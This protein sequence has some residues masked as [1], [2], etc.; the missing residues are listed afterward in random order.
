MKFYNLMFILIIVSLS[1]ITFVSAVEET[2]KP[3]ILERSHNQ[4]VL[5]TCDIDGQPCSLS[6]ACNVS[7]FYPNS[8]VIINNQIA[9]RDGDSYKYSL[10]EQ[11][12]NELGTHHGIATCRISEF[13]GIINFDYL[14][15]PS[16]ADPISEGQGSVIVWVIISLLVVSIIFLVMG[17]K[18]E[19][20][21]LRTAMFSLFGI[22]FVIS[23]LYTII[24][25][26]EY[27]GYYPA[28]VEAYENF[29]F[30]IYGLAIVGIIGLFVVVLFAFLRWWNIKRGFID[31]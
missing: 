4:S 28:L 25:L 17:F 22:F 14:V 15:T 23:I 13:S 9:T 31:P 11:Q 19:N 5:F 2:L 12:T 18:L 29:Y 3:Q 1:S 16:G 6:T 10:N 24:T 20:L 26:N 30:V 27:F 21:V 7:L 8:T